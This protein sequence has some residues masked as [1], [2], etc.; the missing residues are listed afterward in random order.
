MKKNKIKP[1]E[2]P[3]QL[4]KAEFLESTRTV[5]EANG[6]I[7]DHVTYRRPPRM[8]IYATVPKLPK[9]EW[10]GDKL[11]RKKQIENDRYWKRKNKE[12]SI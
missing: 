8:E 10:Y 1:G 11:R 9:G 5:H 2:E 3:V 4:G 6:D 7:T 12:D